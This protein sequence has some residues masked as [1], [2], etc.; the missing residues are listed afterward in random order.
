MKTVAE[1]IAFLE[2]LAPPA[3]A[4][5]WDN[6]GLLLGRRTAEVKR[7][8]TCL[9]VTPESASDAID[10]Q[11]ELVVSHHPVLFKAVRKLTDAT[12]EGRT[13]LT[14]ARAGVAVYSPHTAFDNCPGGINDTLAR[15]IGVVDTVPLVRGSGP[16]ECKVVVFVPEQDLQRV[17]ASVFA[18]GAGRIGQY[19]E[20]SFRLAGTGTFFG[21]ESTN[22]A[23][24]QKGRH[25]EVPEL[26]LEVL[27][28]ETDVPAVVAAV[29]NAHS[30]E[31]PALDVYPLRPGPAATGEGRIG[32]LPGPLTLEAFAA[33]VRAE[34]HCGP[35]QVV[36]D[37]AKTVRRV[38]IVCGAGGSFLSEAIQAQA[39]VLL[40][41]E[42]RFHDYLEAAGRGPGMVLPGHFATERL[43]AE[44]LAR[45]IAAEFPELNAVAST[46]EIDPVRWL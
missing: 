21:S 34:L 38:A 33:R 1:V 32:T 35:V 29:R 11:A 20:C 43:G 30:Y 26:R 24:G 9:T 17:M 45:L 19:S 44:E 23:V 36:G 10:S 12:L 18:A 2:R 6:V 16:A 15:R 22:P 37:P 8:L 39:D 14:L 31:E 40:T 46:S 4:A 28:R 41:G 25:E 3:L 42:A 7:V 27:C 13:L 5:D